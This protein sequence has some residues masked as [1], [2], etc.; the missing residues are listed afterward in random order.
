MQVYAAVPEWLQFAVSPLWS[1]I[2]VHIGLVPCAQLRPSLNTLVAVS[3]TTWPMTDNWPAMESD[4]STG[5]RASVMTWI[6]CALGAA[7]VLLAEGL[8]STVM[9]T[10][11]ELPAALPG[12]VAP[13][14]S[15][16]TVAPLLSNSWPST[17]TLPKARTVPKLRAAECA[18]IEVGLLE[19]PPPPQA[20]SDTAAAAIRI[21]LRV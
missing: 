2:G 12:T 4:A 9:P 10:A 20:S 16:T 17:K 21:A 8:T 18:L 3:R 7:S 19:P 6:S 13:V 1:V 14:S 15:S 5:P 11:S